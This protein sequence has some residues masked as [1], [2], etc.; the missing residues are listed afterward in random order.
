V[1]HLYAFTDAGIELPLVEGI[2]GSPLSL[3]VTG[4][5]AAVVSAVDDGFDRDAVLAHGQVVE[6]LRTTADVVLPVRFGERFVGTAELDAAIAARAGALRARL[7]QVRGCAEFGV[8]MQPPQAEEAPRSGGG[9]YLRARLAS[10]RRAAAIAD[11]LHEPLAQC[12]RE[13]VVT[14]GRDHAAAYLVRHDQRDRF[15]RTLRDFMAAHPDVTVLCTG[16]WAPYSFA[17]AA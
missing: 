10:A 12:A 4:D 9:A 5:L 14:P 15:E 2:G 3:C 16:P 1:I 8:R 7:D 13:A 11:A 6:A 17:E